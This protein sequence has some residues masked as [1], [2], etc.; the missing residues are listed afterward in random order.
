MRFALALLALLPTLAFGQGR[1]PS[2]AATG[3]TSSST[4][5]LQ[6]DPELTTNGDR[7]LRLKNGPTSVLEFATDGTAFGYNLW[8]GSNGI[9]SLGGGAR[10]WAYLYLTQTVIGKGLAGP[11]G[12]RR[13][14]FAN[15]TDSTNIVGGQAN[16]A[17]AIAIKV[18]N[19]AALSTSGAKIVSLYSDNLSTERAFFDKDGQYENLGAGNGIIFKSPD[20]TRYR[21]TVPNGGASL[22]ITGL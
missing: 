22:T 10:A 7:L 11:S 12:E 9:A 17:S 20:G 6:L 15:D 14:D 19:S 21:V 4:V 18:G 5:V 2:G 13:M 8:P 16:G 1:L 3:I